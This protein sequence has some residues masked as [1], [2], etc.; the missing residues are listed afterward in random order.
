MSSN[1]LPRPIRFVLV[2][3]SNTL[4]DIIVFTVLVAGFAVSPVPANIVGYIIGT[5]NS[6][7]LN[8]NW[9]FREAYETDWGG[10]FA[11]FTGVNLAALGLSTAIV[12]T[13]APFLGAVPA[14]LLSVL[15]T[16]FFSYTLSKAIVFRRA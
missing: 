11:R 15:V 3:L 7:V 9:T 14:K 10:Q 5:I 12:W 1:R 8:R 2:G 16:F 13:L 6:F 4:V